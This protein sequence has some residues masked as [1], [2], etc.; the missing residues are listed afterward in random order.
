M[1][2]IPEDFDLRPDQSIK[3]FCHFGSLYRLKHGVLYRF[4]EASDDMS[5]AIWQ[6]VFQSESIA[7]ATEIVSFDSVILFFSNKEKEAMVYAFDTETLV[8]KQL[9]H[10]DGK[11][12]NLIS[13]SDGTN[14]FILNSFGTF[15]RLVQNNGGL[16]FQ[17]VARLWDCQWKPMLA[18]TYMNK[19]VIFGTE[20]RALLD[21]N[22]VRRSLPE[23]FD[24]GIEFIELKEPL[25]C[26]PMTVPRRWF[27]QQ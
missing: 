8:F 20:L 2:E 22:T 7:A 16:V 4:C 11:A 26:C 27:N 15:L 3:L 21:L 14:T 10:F 12:T 1:E 24:D 5:D 13:I 17:P 19:L 18:V 23:F 6:Q 9:P 25:H